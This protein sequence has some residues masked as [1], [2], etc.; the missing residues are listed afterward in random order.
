MP[1]GS[2]AMPEGSIAMPKTHD[3]QCTSTGGMLSHSID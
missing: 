3:V 1:E 2:I